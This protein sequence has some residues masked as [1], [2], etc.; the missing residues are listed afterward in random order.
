M[1]KNP[2]I[3]MVSKLERLNSI[4]TIVISLHR[5]LWRH[6]KDYDV[7]K[8]IMTSHKIFLLEKK[9]NT[10]SNISGVKTLIPTS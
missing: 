4:Y 3:S 5:K 9:N 1:G 8:K 7:T 10:D 6:K 2:K